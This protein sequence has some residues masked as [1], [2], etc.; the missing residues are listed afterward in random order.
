MVNNYTG[1]YFPVYK[2]M[3]RKYGDSVVRTPYTKTTSNVNGDETLTAGTPVTITVYIARKNAA[4]FLDKPGFVE[5]GDAIMIVPSDVTMNKD[6]TITWNGHTYR[7][8][9]VL[10]RDMIGGNTAYRACQL[11]L[12]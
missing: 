8:I 1:V 5:G 9:T 12:L 7:V 2:T 10:N 3:I 4:W 6:D 11:F